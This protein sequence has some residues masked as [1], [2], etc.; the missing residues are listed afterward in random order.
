MPVHTTTLHIQRRLRV[1]AVVAFVFAVYAV[2]AP[3]SHA[4]EATASADIVLFE[5]TPGTLEVASGTSVTW[6]NHDSIV[7]SVSEGTPDAPGDLFDSGLFDQNQTFT[8]TFSEP[9]SY[10]YFCTRHNFMH[11][12]VDVT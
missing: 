7:H 10:T 3:I 12:T 8:Y 4:Q 2:A 5:F 11:G 1:A 6:L 9:G